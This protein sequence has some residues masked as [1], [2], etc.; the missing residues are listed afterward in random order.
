MAHRL[1]TEFPAI[2]ARYRRT[3]RYTSLDEFQD[4]NQAQY[5]LVRAFTGGEYRNLFLV[6]DDDPQRS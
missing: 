3:Y 4:T 6:A 2:A 5:A 1:F